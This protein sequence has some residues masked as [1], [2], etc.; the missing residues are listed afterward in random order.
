[1]T[2]RVSR[3]A[4]TR[5]S[6]GKQFFLESSVDGRSLIARRFREVQSAIVSDLG[7]ES[8]ISEAEMALVRRAVTLVV[9]CEMFE[10]RM[11]ETGKLDSEA[12]LPCVNAL[13]KLLNALGLKRRPRQVG[14]S[15]LEGYHAANAMPRE[16]QT[17]DVEP[18]RDVES[19]P[20]RIDEAI[21]AVANGSPPRRVIRPIR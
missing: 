12:Y 9:N 10:S 4:G 8:F 19:K 14:P 11:A 1:M 21:A 5:L 15:P 20:R 16:P 17:V 18:M 6:N 2:K 3:T 7:G 13:G